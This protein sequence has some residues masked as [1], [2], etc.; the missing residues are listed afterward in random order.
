[1]SE[2]VEVKSVEE[3]ARDI[4][5][6]FPNTGTLKQAIIEVL[7]T[8]R[9]RVK[10]DLEYLN[11]F[12]TERVPW[13]EEQ[14]STLQAENEKL[15]KSMGVWDV[16][17]DLREEN[18]RLK[19]VEQDWLKHDCG[20]L[21]TENASLRGRI[22]ELEGTLKHVTYQKFNIWPGTPDMEAIKKARVTIKF[23]NFCDNKAK[24]AIESLRKEGLI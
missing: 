3:I 9:E 6:R 7:S 4:S 24:E 14:L 12:K 1:M 2:S 18:A 22:E 15:L 8:E 11:W 19:A 23:L 16:V 21:M 20:V 17:K 5:C 13:L 10:E